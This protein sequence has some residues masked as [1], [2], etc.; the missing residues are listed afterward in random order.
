MH[1]FFLALARLD[2]FHGWQSYA[3]L[4]ATAIGLPL[5]YLIARFSLVRRDAAYKRRMNLWGGAAILMGCMGLSLIVLNSAVQAALWPSMM[6]SITQN[7]ALGS[8]LATVCKADPA[9]LREGEM[10]DAATKLRDRDVLWKSVG[11]GAASPLAAA[12]DIPCDRIPVSNRALMLLAT[13]RDAGL[14][15]AHLAAGWIVTLS[16]APLLMLIAL[17]RAAEAPLRWPTLRKGSGLFGGG[18]ATNTSSRETEESAR[19]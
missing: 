11:S 15:G 14:V 17:L 13:A 18:N 1:E 6:G 12:A 19:W 16:L 3:G 9:K 4:L 5:L 2:L 10:A 7:Y 8:A